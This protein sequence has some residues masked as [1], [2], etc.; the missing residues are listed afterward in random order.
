VA[1]GEIN[2]GIIKISTSRAN[3][4]V[5]I[6][7][8]DNGCGIPEKIRSRIFEP[9]FTTKPVGKGS[10]QGL[11]IAHAIVV[12]KHGGQITFESE[13]GKGTTFHIILP[14]DE[15][16]DSGEGIETANSICR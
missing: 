9:F 2:R 13:V 16:L 3:G 12:K 8:S 1:T 5:R 14:L 7:V 4:Y 6:S 15:T 11:A 10:G